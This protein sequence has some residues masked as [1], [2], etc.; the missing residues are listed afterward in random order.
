MS[1]SSVGTSPMLQWLQSYLSSAGSVS[2]NQSCNAS[3]GA[4]SM[5]DTAS[6]SQQAVEL[7][8]DQTEPLSDPS[9]LPDLSTLRAHH[10][11]HHHHGDEQG[12]NQDDGSFMDQL[13]KSIVPDL[14][15]PA[16]SDAS[17]ESN[18]PTDSQ[19][20]EGSF[21]DRLAHAIAN[22]LIAQYQQSPGSDSTRSSTGDTSQVNAVT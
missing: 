2:S 22:D 10:T 20:N 3:C 12:L 17:S 1:V 15:Q 11:H 16:G 9:Q 21:L 6:I 19:G 7:N 4:Q 8:A 5:S 18:A 14:Q 13:A